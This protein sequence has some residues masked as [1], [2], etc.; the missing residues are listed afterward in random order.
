M[1]PLSPSETSSILVHSLR[2]VQH[3][4]Q[5]PAVERLENLGVPVEKIR[6]VALATDQS[7]AESGEAEIIAWAAQDWKVSQEDA[8]K[9]LNGCPVADVKRASLD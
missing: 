6:K 2:G 7:A 1:R 9:L 4:T 3:P 8:L 5:L